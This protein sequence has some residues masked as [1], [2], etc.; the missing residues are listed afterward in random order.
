MR[1][2]ASRESSSRPHAGKDCG[3]SRFTLVMLLAAAL[4]AVAAN[5]TPETWAAP[6]PE[7]DEARILPES[8]TQKNEESLLPPIGAD[9]GNALHPS[10][11]GENMQGHVPEGME[12]LQEEE[13]EDALEALINE[14]IPELEVVELDLDTAKRALDAFAEVFGKFPDEEI[15]KYPTLQEFAEKSPLGRKFADIIHKHGF[16]SVREWNN[17]ITNIGFAFSSIEEG[18][19]DEIVRQ[20]TALE[21]RGDMD[22]KRK[23]RLLKYLRALIPSINNRKVVLKLLSEPEYRKKLELLEGGAGEEEGEEAHDHGTEEE[24]GEA[25]KTSPGKE[26]KKP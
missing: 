16:K 22:E 7:K 14:D 23:E 8:P 17:V 26:D 6:V 2:T 12:D 20:I 25:G 10:V 3:T 4:P 24:S 21:R 19:D 18:H 9:D 13:G 5:N 15:A 11:P 1:R